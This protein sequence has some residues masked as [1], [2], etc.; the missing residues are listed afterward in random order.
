M[1]ILVL[2]FTNAHAYANIYNLT[3]FMRF[4]CVCLF[5]KFNYTFITKV[6]LTGGVSTKA[7]V[8]F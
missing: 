5:C 4:V 1:F 2:L 7:A 8:F 6:V 3:V